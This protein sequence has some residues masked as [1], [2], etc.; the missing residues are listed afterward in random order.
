MQKRFLLTPNGIAAAVG[1][2]ESELAARSAERASALRARLALEEVCLFYASAFGPE[3]ACDLAL[4]R[5]LGR[6]RIRLSVNGL[7]NDPLTTES[8]MA[9]LGR[10]SQFEDFSPRWSWRNGA[11]T[12]DIPV[13]TTRRH[14][15]ATA[16]MVLML[17]LGVAAGGLATSCLP[18]GCVQVAVRGSDRLLELALDVMKGVAGPFIFVS[19]VFC[20]C[21]IGSLSVFTRMG[22]RLFAW[23]MSCLVGASVLSTVIARCFVTSGS[24]AV[25]SGGGNVLEFLL[26]LVPVNVFAPFVQGNIPQ[27]LVLAFI[28]GRTM[29]AFGDRVRALVDLVEQAKVIL[30]DLLRLALEVLLPVLILL[31]SFSMVASGRLSVIL[32]SWKISVLMAVASLASMSVLLALGCLRFREWPL[33][34]FRTAWPAIFASIPTGSSIAVLP[35]EIRLLKEKFG[36]KED[37]VDFAEPFL[38]PFSLLSFVLQLSVM[39]VCMGAENGLSLTADWLALVIAI[40]PLAAISTPPV[41]GGGGVVLGMLCAQLGIRQDCIGMLVAISVAFDYAFTWVNV[42]CRLCVVRNVAYTLEKDPV[43]P[44]VVGQ[45][46]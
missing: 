19:V 35:I 5:R 33:A 43:R 46:G 24:A 13:R 44:Q 2:L 34:F 1:E 27:I 45:A 7:P 29:L 17:V 23:I 9:I 42:C 6:L 4:V 16:L 12:V 22:L 36:V 11:N 25:V 18:A 41:T 38:L 39:M 15:S 32:A 30:T 28:V 8:D 3:A 20:I 31:C 26:G 40:V 21:A 10:L 14:F 37:F